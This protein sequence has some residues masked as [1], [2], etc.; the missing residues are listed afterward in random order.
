MR[1]GA[2]AAALLACAGC[3]GGAPRAT[4]VSGTTPAAQPSDDPVL[5]AV[6]VFERGEGGIPRPPPTPAAP[7]AEP[8]PAE[9]EFDLPER[10]KPWPA[11]PFSTFDARVRLFLAVPFLED[12]V[13]FSCAGS[14]HA[15][16][17]WVTKGL[18]DEDPLVRLRALVVLVRLRAPRT[19]EK[20]WATL[21]ALE[22]GPRGAEFA[23]AT[24]RVRA[25]FAPEAIDR[26][27]ADPPPATEYSTP[28]DYQW[29]LR[30]AGVTRH[31]GALD[32]LAELSR[33]DVLHVSLSAERSLED[34]EGP[35]AD[36][37]LARCVDGWQYNASLRAAGALLR[38]D[39]ERL[40]ATLAELDPPEDRAYWKGI[41]L[42]RLE[43]ARAVPIL[44]RTVPRISL[45]DG[46]MFDAIE[47][48]AG[49]A[50]LEG[51]EALPA[52]VREGQRARATTVVERVRTR[53]A[54]AR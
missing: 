28:A 37:A 22:R 52:R 20:Q 34:F 26:T 9:E 40:R 48:L 41:Y 29:A 32:R 36:A 19:V 25:A 39:P 12:A 21:E 31:R 2:I 4:T 18:D 5:R 10:S 16:E 53:L 1:V 44:C 13:Q 45:I 30:A 23:Q 50:D 7:S 24:T 11:T 51:V 15:D 8:P 42:A 33:S 6:A 43:D 54:A 27:L 46:E 38:R 14:V 17:Y 35:D 3:G 47:R 49:P